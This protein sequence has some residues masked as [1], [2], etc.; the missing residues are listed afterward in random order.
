MTQHMLT[1][2]DNPYD[3]FT[4]FD[5]WYAYDT[6]MGYHT[7]AY[8]ARVTYT[9]DELSETDQDLAIETAIDEVVKLNPLGLYRK[10]A[11]TVVKEE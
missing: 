2:I 4:R 5:E 10:V 9:S 11:E 6:S 7:S 8:L 3:P 1:T